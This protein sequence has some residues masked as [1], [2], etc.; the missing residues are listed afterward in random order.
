MKILLS[1]GGTLGPVTPLLA[2][3]E[4]IRSKYPAASFV[5]VGTPNGPEKKLVEN[6]GISF[7]PLRSGKLR[8]YRSFLN[9][10]D[11]WK[12]MNAFFWSL[13]FLRREKPNVC[14]SAGGFV[15]VPI[16]V[17]AWMLRIP[18]WIHQQDVA[19]GLANRLMAFFATRITTAL[20]STTASHFF[21]S[22][23][24]WIGN[25][26]RKEIFFGNSERGRKR[27][28][29]G[30]TLPVVF[31]TGG[32]TGAHSL[33]RLIIEALPMLQSHCH[34]IHLTG[35]DRAKDIV[36]Q[37]SEKYASF[38]HPYSFFTHEMADA[39]ALA[40]V[41]VARGGFGTITELAALSKAAILVPK[42]GHQEKN[43]TFLED[44]YAVIAFHEEKGTEED[45]ARHILDLLKDAKK[46]SELGCKLHESIPI[47]S[48]VEMFELIKS[49]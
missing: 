10:V 4:A 37:I 34:V 39:Y 11:V 5:W 30:D 17:A 21:S 20:E 49:Y 43:I 23:T 32:G 38:Y 36:D 1:G 42:F 13:L 16:H 35:Q 27:W 2:I 48:D 25:P 44:R 12:T 3:A 45:L 26:V 7:F 29:I 9:V 18:T 40:D 8:R 28:G 33:N 41:V 46:R 15:S 22:K 47:P 14:I 6:A 31:V 19:V 24:A